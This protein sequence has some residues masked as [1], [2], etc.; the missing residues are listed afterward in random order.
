MPLTKNCTKWQK[1]ITMKINKRGIPIGDPTKPKGGMLWGNSD[2]PEFN[3]LY[4][5]L[6]GWASV[7]HSYAKGGQ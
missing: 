5:E 4:D 7:F 3:L 1:H 6:E 2:W